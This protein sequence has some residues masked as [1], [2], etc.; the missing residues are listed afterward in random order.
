MKQ[1]SVCLFSICIVITYLQRTMEVR[2]EC[3]WNAS[4]RLCVHVLAAL[5]VSAVSPAIGK[6]KALQPT[7]G[8]IFSFCWAAELGYS[9]G[10]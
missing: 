1:I 2:W 3:C 8:I 6:D 10:S 7:Q 5:A 9:I 4:N